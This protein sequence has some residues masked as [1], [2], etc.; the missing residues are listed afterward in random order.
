[1]HGVTLL[2]PPRHRSKIV[3]GRVDKLLTQ[4]TL[5]HQ[6]FIRDPT[7]T[8]EGERWREEWLDSWEQ[9]I[10]YSASAN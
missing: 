3:A 4:Q 1:M 8:V 2:A 5:L 7:K 6:T 9:G 10:F